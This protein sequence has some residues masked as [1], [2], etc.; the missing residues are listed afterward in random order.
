MPTCGYTVTDSTMTTFNRRSVIA[1]IGGTA[2][3]SFAGCLGDDD[4][5]GDDNGN[6]NGDGSPADRA[7]AFLSDNDARM[8]DGDIE[9][10]TGEDEVTVMVGAGDDGLAFDPAAIRIDTGT[11]VVWEW[12]GV[13]GQHNVQPTGD[14]DWD[15]FG[16]TERVDEEGHTVESTFD[17]EGVGLYVCQPHAGQ[18][19]YGAVVVE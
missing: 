5:N 1:G 3:A 19:M 17:E 9:D 2:L 4:D 14:T 13:G 18:R 6:G 15:D 8:Y 11:T 16:D 12:T 10:H 7:D